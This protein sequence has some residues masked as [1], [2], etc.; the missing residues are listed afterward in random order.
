MPIRFGSRRKLRDWRDF[1]R[2]IVIIV[3][4]VLIALGASHVAEQWNWQRRVDEAEQLLAFESAQNFSYAVEAVAV[5]PCIQRQ[6]EVLR[7]RIVGSAD[8]LVPAPI[9]PGGF[10]DFV[11]RA[12]S[13]PMGT[14]IWR[15]LSADGTVPHLEYGRQYRYALIDNQLAMA[16]AL[17][18]ETDRFVGRLQVLATPIALDASTRAR[19]LEYID[20]QA[21]RSRLHSLVALQVMGS[22]RD[23]G[24]APSNEA[25]L[26]AI[27]EES[28]TA[29]LCREQ[30]WP[31]ADWKSDLAA[32]PV[33]TF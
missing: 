26:R 19:L 9:H 14:T 7:T 4:G 3:V 5:G 16:G 33:G 1:A 8:T 30:G 18:A 22:I 2:E 11:F 23:L 31:L 32:L 25:D 12:P 21:H 20:E 17:S 13:R 15:A 6:L 10:S 24:N 29:T 27:M 28:G